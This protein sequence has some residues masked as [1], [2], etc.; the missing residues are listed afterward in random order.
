MLTLSVRTVFIAF[1]FIA[2]DAAALCPRFGSFGGIA[3]VRAS[4]GREKKRR[5][6]NLMLLCHRGFGKNRIC[7]STVGRVNFD[8]FKI[9]KY[10]L[11]RKRGPK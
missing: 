6:E 3:H 9:L 2:V 10:F 4:A 8:Q 11:F 1:V 5:K 7:L